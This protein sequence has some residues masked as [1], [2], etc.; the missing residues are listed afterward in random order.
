MIHN[1]PA[2]LREAGRAKFIILVTVLVLGLFDHYFLTLQQGQ[3]LF[4]LVL[5]IVWS[6]IEV[7]GQK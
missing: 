3:L 7:R 4:S 2:S 1:S 5:G 6:R